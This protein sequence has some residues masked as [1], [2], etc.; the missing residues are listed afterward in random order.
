MT[1]LGRYSVFIDRKRFEYLKDSDREEK[2]V[3]N[4]PIFN[5]SEL[6]FYEPSSHKLVFSAVR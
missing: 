3:S 6:D 1:Q 2:S 4:E 5:G